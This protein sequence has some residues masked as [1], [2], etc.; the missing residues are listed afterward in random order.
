M[1][2]LCGRGISGKIRWSLLGLIALAVLIRCVASSTS[3]AQEAEEGQYKSMPV[4]ISDRDASRLYPSVNSALRN[5]AGFGA[6]K[7]AV[8]NYLAK[9]YLPKMTSYQP[10]DLAELAKNREKLFKNFIGYAANASSRQ[11]LVDLLFKFSRVVVRDNFHPAVRY[12]AVLLLGELDQELATATTP[13]VPLPAATTE[14]LELV[15][16]SEVNGVPVPESVKLGALIGL[17]RHARYRIDPQLKDRLT[18]SMLAVLAD[19]EAPEDVDSDVHDW[20]LT[21]AAQVLANQYAK[22]PTQE[23]QD[24][25][26]SLIADEKLGLDDRCLVASLLKNITYTE[27]SGVDA[28]ATVPAI[29]QLSL[30]VVEQGAKLARKYQKEALGAGGLVAPGFGGGGYGGR[31]GYGGEFG[32]GYGGG[33]GGEFGG[34]F[35]G[36][37]MEDTGPKFER[38]RLMARL[39][40][41]ARGANSLSAGLPDAGKDQIASLLTEMK[42]TIQVIEDKDA[43]EV[44]VTQAVIE[45]EGRLKTL[46]ATWNLPGDDK[47]ADEAGDDDFAG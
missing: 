41:V 43:V 4:T 27:G 9:N 31:G 40:D 21:V 29:G 38:R 11:E 35:G 12:N 25:L 26:T 10:E 47:P 36:G 17:E 3:Y 8:V 22:E 7:E 45:L 39:M 24:A 14:L 13:P 33:Y 44:K 28:A 32:G 46:L 19:R 15:E 1:C 30:D 23:V 20:L 42:P 6:E 2:A 18:K 34:G 37:A 5:P 16:Q